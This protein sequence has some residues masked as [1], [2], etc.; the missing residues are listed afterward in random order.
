[1]SLNETLN[2]AIINHQQGA[3]DQ[4]DQLYTQVL[5]QHPQLVEALYGRGVLLQAKGE[6]LQ[7][8]ALLEQALAVEARVQT[9]NALGHGAVN[10]KAYSKAKH[11]YEQSLA[12]QANADAY[13]GVAVCLQHLGQL[14]QA[15]DL[16]KKAA[17]LEPI[18]MPL[19]QNLGHCA[20]ALK[21]WELA[22]KAFE[23]ANYIEKTVASTLGIGRVYK[24]QEKLQEALAMFQDA[25]QMDPEDWST[26]MD[27]GHVYRQLNQYDEA[28]AAFHKAL[29]LD[30]QNE[31]ACY[32]LGMVYNQQKQIE[33]ALHWF[34]QA[35]VRK[36]NWKDAFVSIGNC[37]L[38]IYRFDEALSYFKR[39]LE[40]NAQDANA[41]SGLGIVAFKQGNTKAALE[42]Y[43]QAL[44]ITP[45]SA[46][47]RNNRGIALLKDQQMEAGWADYEWRLRTN[48]FL[49]STIG[50]VSWQGESLVGKTILVVGEQ[51]LGDNIMITRY[52]PLLLEEADRV[53]VE[54]L[55][56]L[57]PWFQ[58]SFESD[59]VTIRPHQPHDPPDY[60]YY[61]LSM[62]L[63]HCFYPKHPGIPP[64]QGVLTVRDEK[65][66][67][68]KAWPW[69]TGHK[70]VG[71][72][73]AAN[74]HASSGPLRSCPLSLFEPL[75]QIPG[76]SFYSL[77]KGE[78]QE[79]LAKA[80]FAESV[81]DLSPYL[82]DLEDTAAAMKEM[83]LVITV[84][85]APLH[86][87]G[88]MDVAVWGVMPFESDWRWFEDLSTSEWYPSLTIFRQPTHRAWA[89][90]MGQVYDHLVRWAESVG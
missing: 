55:P 85:S 28:K 11:Y 34:E 81:V 29:A 12:I 25:L 41:L 5:S 47:V 73:W 43:A 3:L 24:A 18:R 38:E 84:D 87:A 89:I 76:L 83:D 40:I 46:A 82:L 63:P 6:Y 80:P 57:I 17:N 79:D 51:G 71:L 19:H 65:R 68:W 52:F 8:E 59:R 62:S 16:F 74:P 2:E 72:V 20:S 66:D 53:I 49:K 90:V 60:D 35:L 39:A 14:D 70:R 31:G 69:V 50:G 61:C 88:A 58:Q 64:C 48:G 27:L 13:T 75:T 4:A 10:Q 26:W 23:T 9:L 67:Y 15:L 56:A 78:P 36:P 45:D 54:C 30:S 1:M 22:L 42:Y 21:E 32:G 44:E 37:L 86:I 77:Q 33:D 7:A